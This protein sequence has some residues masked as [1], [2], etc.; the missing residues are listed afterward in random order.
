MIAFCDAGWLVCALLLF[1]DSFSVLILLSQC[2]CAAAGE[3]SSIYSYL[4]ITLLIG[5]ADYFI[6]SPFAVM[7]FDF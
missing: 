4:A 7:L 5:C 6:I 1:S 2:F 3:S